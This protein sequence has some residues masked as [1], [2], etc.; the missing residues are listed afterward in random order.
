MVGIV[1]AFGGAFLIAMGGITASIT[2][3]LALIGK[4]VELFGGLLEGIGSLTKTEGL[5]SFGESLKYAGENA[6]QFLLDTTGA[7]LGKGIENY[8][9]WI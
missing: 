4:L 2:L 7:F 3:P 5:R 6:K 9:K 1:Q 8:C